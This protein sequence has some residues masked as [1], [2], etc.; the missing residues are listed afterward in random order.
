M[1]IFFYSRSCVTC[2]NLMNIMKNINI[3]QNFNLYCVDDHLNNLP[4]HI[5][6]IPT[7]IVGELKQQFVAGDAFKWVESVKFMNQKHAME[8]NKKNIM[9]NMI[10]QQ[11]L[12][13]PHGYANSEMGGFSDS[14]AFT[15]VDHAQAHSFFGYKS[16]NDNTI[17]TAPEETEKISQSEQKKRMANVEINRKEQDKQNEVMMKNNQINA[18][19]E[20]EKQK[21]REFEQLSR[22]QQLRM[23]QNGRK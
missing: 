3:L 15:D 22:S 14:F 23:N 10:K 1:N 5:T 20:T 13:G 21:I 8:M 16:E 7:L 11:Q 19:I 2:A 17:F 4:P 12:M 6:T 18:V 9:A